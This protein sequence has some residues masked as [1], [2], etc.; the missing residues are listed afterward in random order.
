MPQLFAG[1]ILLAAVAI[2]FNETV[3]WLETRCSTWRM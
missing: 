2:A 3:R 1:V